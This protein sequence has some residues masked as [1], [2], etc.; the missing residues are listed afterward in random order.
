MKLKEKGNTS[1]KASRS[2]VGSTTNKRLNQSPFVDGQLLSPGKLKILVLSGNSISN[3]Q[4]GF[5]LQCGNLL[6]LDLSHNA[7]SHIPSKIDFRLMPRLQILHFNDNRIASIEAIEP[8]LISPVL[9]CLVYRGNPIQHI[10]S[11]E[12][13]IVNRIPSLKVINDRVVFVE[14]RSETIVYPRHNMLVQHDVFE[15][16]NTS[17]NSEEYF[18]KILS[19]QLKYLDHVHAFNN[20]II[21]IQRAYRLYAGRKNKKVPGENKK[22]T[23]KN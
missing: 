17:D 23:L 22:E 2:D 13:V 19:L 15:N 5:L 6:K 18:L 16:C 3:H 10:R 4:L 8:V 14:E 20:P 7:I 21:I 9:I 12:H 1:G 11:A